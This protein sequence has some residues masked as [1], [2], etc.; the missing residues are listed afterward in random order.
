MAKLKFWYMPG[1]CSL[2]PHILL[3]ELGLDVET[4]H[5]TDLSPSGLGAI[6][7]KR[8]VPV[9]SIDGEI[10]TEVPAILTALAQLGSPDRK[11]LGK[12]PIETARV[13]EWMNWLSGQLHGIGYGGLWR[14]ERYSDDS[15]ALESIKM[16]GKLNIIA[17][18]EFVESRIEGL[19]AVGD[20]FTVVDLY[21]LVFYRWGMAIELEMEK[22]F[23]KY[24][25]LIANLVKRDAVVKTLEEVKLPPLFAPKV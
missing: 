11:L 22:D 2:A 9:L 12:T 13:Y 17:A 19:H 8:R 6:N 25:A 10:I 20:S 23:P 14:S 24:T 4:I 16:K 7:P 15:N 1:S 5:V 18:Y 21:L 3:R